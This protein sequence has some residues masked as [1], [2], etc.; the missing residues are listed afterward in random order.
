MLEETKNLMLEEDLVLQQGDWVPLSWASKQ[1]M[2]EH[3]KAN[4]LFPQCW[5]DRALKTV[6]M[7]E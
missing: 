5:N 3:K 4:C 7:A 6:S 2:E 1:A